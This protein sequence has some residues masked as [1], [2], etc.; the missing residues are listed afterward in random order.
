MAQTFSFVYGVHVQNLTGMADAADNLA[1]TAANKTAELEVHRRSALQASCF[2]AVFFGAARASFPLRGELLTQ[3]NELVRRS[4]DEKSKDK[5]RDHGSG[6][7]VAL[8]M[9]QGFATTNP[10]ACN[11]FVAASAKV[12]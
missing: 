10:G 9:N 2:G 8:W 1:D 6:K 11:T 5:A 7:S 4:G 3:W 12:S